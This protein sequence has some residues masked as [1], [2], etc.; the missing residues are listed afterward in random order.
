M[1]VINGGTVGFN[2]GCLC[3][4]C[5]IDGRPNGT[6][7]GGATFCFPACYNCTVGN[8]NCAFIVNGNGV[9]AGCHIGPLN[10]SFSGTHG[11]A[12]EPDGAV[13]TMDFHNN[14]IHDCNE[15]NIMLGGNPVASGN[16]YIY[17]NIIYNSAPGCILLKTS[18]GAANAAY[19]WNNVLDSSQGGS[20]SIL[21][22]SG[23]WT[24]LAEQNNLEIKGT[25]SGLFTSWT[26]DHN[27]NVSPATAS[28]AGL[29]SANLYYNSASNMTWAAGTNLTGMGL[30]ALT[31]DLTGVPRSTFYGWDAGPYQVSL[32][33]PVIISLTT[34]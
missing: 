26:R 33:P 4:N 24:F 34:N 25:S 29:S 15:I 12:I 11:A 2:P 21:E 18:P 17:N 6:D 10:T 20:Y 9:I 28:A 13:G 3:S 7:S 30:S 32:P 14:F 31:N 23:T 22:E 27:L 5:V 16:A 8:M 19:V 1:Q